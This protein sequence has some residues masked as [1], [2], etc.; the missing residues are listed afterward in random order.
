VIIQKIGDSEKEK[1][2]DL[3]EGKE[4]Q[5]VNMKVELVE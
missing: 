2:Y 1:I 3:F 4:G 5:I